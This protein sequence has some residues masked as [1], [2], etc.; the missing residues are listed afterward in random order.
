MRL[1]A[2]IGTT[3]SR[4]NVRRVCLLRVWMVVGDVLALLAVHGENA[5]HGANGGSISVQLISDP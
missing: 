2:F 1:R 3:Q 4:L 5:D